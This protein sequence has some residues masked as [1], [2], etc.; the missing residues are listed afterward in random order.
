MVSRRRI[1]GA[2]GLAATAPG[3]AAL[4][5]L[6]GAGAASAQPGPDRPFRAV[7]PLV[8]TDGPRAAV[9]LSFRN[10]FQGGAVYLSVQH[11]L[12]AEARLFGRAYALAPGAGV[13]EGFVGVGVADPPGP[14]AIGI[15]G[16]DLAGHA[17]TYSEPITIR[18]TSWTYDDIWLPPPDPH[19]PPPLEPEQPRLDALYA[20]VTPRQWELPFIIP[21]ELG[22]PV[23]ISGYF[24]EQRSFN[25]GPRTGHHGGT[26]IGAPMGTPVRSTNYG[27]V[28]LSELTLVRGELVV[29]D[30]GAGV[31]SCYGHLSERRVA[32]GEQVRRGDIVGLVGSTGLSSGPH[33]HWELSVGGVLVDGLRWLDGTQ[34]F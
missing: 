2:L 6:P 24:G 19:A 34:G 3:L 10:P 23:F 16:V 21:V 11:A 5:L 30:H 33:L 25:G 26:D 17:F 28:V 31:L 8:G 12:A 14:A 29:V 20:T 13:L 4:R 15:S 7:A 32:V 27:T 9:T 22:G 1:L 18:A